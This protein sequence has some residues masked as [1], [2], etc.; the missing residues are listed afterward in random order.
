MLVASRQ[1]FA[2]K[3]NPNEKNLT[4][5]RAA[6]KLLNKSTVDPVI[7]FIRNVALLRSRMNVAL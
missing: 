5:E 3:N 1:N 6:I 4:T 7:G 2:R